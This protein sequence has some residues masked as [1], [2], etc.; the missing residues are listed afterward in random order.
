MHE[1]PTS[2]D[3][4]AFAVGPDGSV[5]RPGVHPRRYTQHQ[6]FALLVLREFLKVDY[7]GLE[8]ILR[9]PDRLS[10]SI[11]NPKSRHSRSSEPAIRPS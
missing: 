3:Q 11:V 8:Q 7:R 6:L 5:R 1:G 9:F 10:L 4:V 2:Y